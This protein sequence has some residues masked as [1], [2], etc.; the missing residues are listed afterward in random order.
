MPSR[1]K[2][3]PVKKKEPTPTPQPPPPETP[4]VEKT[5]VMETPLPPTPEI[6]STGE[7]SL[8][9]LFSGLEEIEE[10]VNADLDPGPVMTGAVLLPLVKVPFSVWARAADNPEYELKDGEAKVLAD[11]L[12]PVLNQWGMGGMQYAEEI[13]LLIVASGL[14]GARVAKRDNNNIRAQGNGEVNAGAVSGKPDET[15]IDSGLFR[16]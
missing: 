3:A 8:E 14:I 16:G 15:P 9:D 5:P 6:S 10:E 12:A 11:A 13:T 2:K 7:P 4:K 1:P